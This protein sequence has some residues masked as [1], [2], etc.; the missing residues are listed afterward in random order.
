MWDEKSGD[1]TSGTKHLGTK[2]KWYETSSTL[3]EVVIRDPSG[4]SSLYFFNLIYIGLGIWAPHRGGKLDLGS[5]K[6][7][8]GC[9]SYAFMFSASVSTYEAQ[10]PVCFDGHILDMVI[11]TQ[12][13]ANI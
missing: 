5:N 3:W 10:G 1:E 13:T 4:C 6:S 12:I 2:Q 8:I 11:P 9:L 7:I